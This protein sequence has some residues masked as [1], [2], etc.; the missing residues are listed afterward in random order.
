MCVGGG[1]GG[2]DSIHIHVIV[3]DCLIP[4]IAKV[5]EACSLKQF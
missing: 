2:G 3:S 5:K 1:G 4:V